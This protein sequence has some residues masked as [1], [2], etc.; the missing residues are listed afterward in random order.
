M[1][2]KEVVQVRI[3]SGDTV[4][5]RIDGGRQP[6]REGI[7]IEIAGCEGAAGGTVV[8]VRWTDSG[9]ISWIPPSPDLEV[10][11]PA[12]ELERADLGPERTLARRS[13]ASRSSAVG[14]YHPKQMKG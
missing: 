9:H 12:G 14:C 10:I 5:V 11:H 1:A 4:R 3:A 13:L 8:M 7:V 2:T 6:P